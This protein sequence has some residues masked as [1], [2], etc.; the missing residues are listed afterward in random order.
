MISGN[1]MEKRVEAAGTQ[2]DLACKLRSVKMY[3]FINN[4]G[5]LFIYFLDVSKNVGL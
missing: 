2:S 4:E 3:R 5:F 1:C